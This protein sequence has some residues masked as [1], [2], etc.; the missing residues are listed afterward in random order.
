MHLARRIVVI[1]AIDA[2]ALWL[3]ALIVP[4]LELTGWVWAI[5]AI[6]VIGL[7]NAL[8]RPFLLVVMLPFTVLSLGLL[9]VVLNAFIVLLADLALPGLNV[10]DLVAAVWT[11]LGIAL[12]NTVVT[13]LLS[14]ND[15]ESFYR[16]VI[17]RFARRSSPPDRSRLPGL[18]IVEIDG[19]STPALEAALAAGYMPILSRWLHSGRF[20]LRSWNCGLPS[21]TS[22]SQAGILYGRND[23]IPAFRWYEKS[24]QRLMISNRPWTASEIHERISDGTGLLA[25]DGSSLTNLVSGDAPNTAMTMSSL[26]DGAGAMRQRSYGYYLLFLNPYSFSRTLVLMLGELAREFGQRWRAKLRRSQEPHTRGG[27]FPLLRA[28]SNVFLRD[29]N[30]YLLIEDMLGGTP[31]VYSTFLGYDVVAH[32]A[33][34]LNRD[35]LQTLKQFDDGIGALERAARRAPRPYQFVLLSDHGQSPGATFRQRFGLTLEELI[36]RALDGQEHVVGP[37]IE[38]ESWAHLNALLSQAIQVE[39]VAGRTARRVLRRRTQDGYVELGP[40]AKA[41]EQAKSEVV[42]CSSGNMGLVYFTGTERRL[43][44]EDLTVRYPRLISVLVSHP[45]IGFILVKSDLY[46]AV[47]IGR[48]GTNY[49]DLE[50]VDGVNPLTDF[51]PD[52]AREL[53]RLDSYSN[54]GDV[55]INSVYFRRTG[56]VAAF[57]DLVGSHGGLG[58][59]QTNAFIIYPEEWP[60]PEDEISSPVELNRQLRNWL[61]ECA[62]PQTDPSNVQ[63]A[64]SPEVVSGA[65]RI[66]HS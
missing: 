43:T 25:N 57:E 19:L 53:K 24:D 46:G 59:D 49:L 55:L 2:L 22:S 51:G 35:A 18:I 56:E 5:W 31:I 54:I 32:H 8:V 64:E 58:G 17:M 36:E 66:R 10:A 12:V 48:Q 33:G 7:L 50:H 29:L 26:L 40:T 11:V 52:A 14:I 45:G 20:R 47:V 44:L 41:P 23:N 61:S 37:P 21:Q 60:D 15:D 63:E 42:V 4:G 9:S 3:L 1:W 6:A 27:S 62:V 30:L 39:S 38:D 16:N 65:E 28:A 34:P 13:G